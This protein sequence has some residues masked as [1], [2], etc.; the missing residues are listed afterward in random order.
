[1]KKLIAVILA[2][3]CVLSLT[4]CGDTLDNMAYEANKKI[5]GSNNIINKPGNTLNEIVDDFFNQ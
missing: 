1:M 2:A 5:S 3:C 4:G